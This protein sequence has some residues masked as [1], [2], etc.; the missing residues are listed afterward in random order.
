MKLKKPYQDINDTLAHLKIQVVE[1]LPFARQITPRF[2]NPAQL[3]AWLKKK[4]HY[5]NDPKGVE[6]LQTMQTMLSGEFWGRRGWGD[7]DCFTIATLAA[8]ITQGWGGL[9]IALVGRTKKNPVHIYTVIYQ[10]G[11]RYV[12]DFTNAN[13]NQERQ[14]YRYIQEIPVKYK[15]WN[16]RN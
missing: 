4:L 2:E 14:T 12:L 1:S 13:F 11:K 7:C 15:N 6:L 3:F 9:Y 8:A 5:K 16:L 10:N